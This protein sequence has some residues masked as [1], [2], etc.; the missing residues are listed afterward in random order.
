MKHFAWL[1][2][3]LCGCGPVESA[4]EAGRRDIGSDSAAE[5]DVYQRLGERRDAPASM[6]DDSESM[7]NIMGQ[8]TELAQAEGQPDQGQPLGGQAL[9][10]K[11]IYTAEVDLVVEQLAGVREKVEALVKKSGGYVAKSNLRGTS[12]RPRGADWTVRIPVEKY[13]EFLDAAQALGEVRTLSSNSQDVSE[14]FYDVEARIRNKKLEESRL[15]KHLEEST[16]KLEDIL[17]VEGEISRVR[18]EIEQM[19]GRLRVLTNLTSLTTVT[20]RVTE[21]KNYVPEAA[22]TYGTR[23]GRSFAASISGLVTF[24]QNA[25]ILAV[26]VAPWAGAFLVPL[27]LFIALLRSL[28]RRFRARPAPVSAA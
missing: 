14:E 20:L 11:I 28:L 17:A 10:R 8:A 22:P 5:V 21:I 25:S 18:G 13:G 3:F 1:L 9:E 26:V 2:F 4:R 16:G 6:T 19:E 27:L 24:A 7:I 23:V 15:L 12:G